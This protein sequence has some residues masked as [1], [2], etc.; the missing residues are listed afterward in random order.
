MSRLIRSRNEFTMEP[1]P[2]CA[3]FAHY[4]NRRQLDYFGS[5]FNRKSPKKS[6][7]HNL[8][9]A[10]INGCQFCECLVQ[11]YEVRCGISE[12]RD[13]IERNS[14]CSST[15]FLIMVGSRV[16]NQDPSHDLS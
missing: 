5:L 6:Q 16:I 2:R 7:F 9:F 15:T 8:T 10:A 12:N 3:P 1:S 4:D 13:F 14:H 11:S